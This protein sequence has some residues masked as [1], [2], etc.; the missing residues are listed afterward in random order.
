MTRPV[1]PASPTDFDF[2]VG[3]WRVR[4]RRLKERLVGSAEWEEFDGR[5]DVSTVLGGYANLDDTVLQMPSG[6]YRALALRAFDPATAT[7][8]IWWLDAR[9]PR[10][11]GVPVVG[12]FD[13]GEGTFL[14]NETLNDRPI[15]VRFRWT[16]VDSGSPHWEQAFS[17]DGGTTW[18]V[19]WMMDFTR[20]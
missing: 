8:S 13:N 4:H 16:R 18:E 1:D 15:V 3:R 19:N 12:R 17:P 11:L 2:Y 10:S 9:D 6:T 20:V 7:W 5:V 14:A